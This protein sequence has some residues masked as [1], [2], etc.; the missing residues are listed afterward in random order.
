MHNFTHKLY[1]LTEQDNIYRDHLSNCSLPDLQITQQRDQA[2]ILLAAP[3]IVAKQLSEFPKVEWIQSIYAGVDA[4]MS[5]YLQQDYELT[6]IKDAFGQPIAEYVIGMLTNYYRHFSSYKEQQVSYNWQPHH[7]QSL[8]GKNVLIL[9][10]GSIGSHLAKILS[11]FN[12]QVSAV[13]STGIPPKELSFHST[14]HVNELSNALSMADIIVNTLPSTEQT[15]LLLNQHSLQ[16]C[17]QA[18]L[19]NVGRGSTLCESGLIEALNSGAIKHAFLDVFKQEPLPQSSPL[20]SHAN[21]TI[22]PHIAA[23]SDPKL[24]V[25]FFAKNYHLWRDGFQLENRVDFDKGY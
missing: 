8:A 1:I 15:R 18:L 3:P 13:N 5:P 7:Y 25:E 11:L 16:H 12:M 4:L 22:T 10:S 6:N 17:R 24:V 19:F 21:I 14:F 9:G 23:L 2:T 20:W